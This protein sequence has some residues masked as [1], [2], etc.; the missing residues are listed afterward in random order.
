MGPALTRHSGNSALPNGPRGLPFVVQASRLLARETQAGRLHHNDAKRRRG[1]MCCTRRGTPAPQR[2][3]RLSRSANNVT[4]NE[5]QNSLFDNLA[6]GYSGPRCAPAGRTVL[7]AADDARPRVP[8]R[9]VR[10]CRA[11][12]ERARLT[13]DR[14]RARL[15][16]PRR[17][18]QRHTKRRTDSP[19][20][21]A[22]WYNQS[23]A[24]GDV[25]FRSSRLGCLTFRS[26]DP[27]GPKQ[28]LADAKD[29]MAMKLWPREVEGR[30]CGFS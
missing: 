23:I 5:S 14:I 24:E 22:L 6:V 30:C 17:F 16:P 25:D 11:P 21:H 9:G 19:D 2:C 13:G 27:A 29:I 26:C 3:A 20:A 1:G 8:R 28:A 4:T 15:G 12:P 7:C 18:I 10:R